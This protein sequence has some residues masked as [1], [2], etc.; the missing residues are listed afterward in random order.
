MRQDLDRILN[1][2]KPFLSLHCGLQHW[3]FRGF[4][5]VHLVNMYLLLLGVHTAGLKTLVLQQLQYV[6]DVVPVFE[7]P[8][9]L[10]SLICQHILLLSCSI[11]H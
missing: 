6:S 4:A 11:V 1:L 9:I 5:A 8:D 7:L 3:S 10:P 2:Q